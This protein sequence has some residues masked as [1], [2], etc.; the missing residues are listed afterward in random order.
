MNLE[1][2]NTLQTEHRCLLGQAAQIG[3]QL[4]MIRRGCD[5]DYSLL[6][7]RVEFLKGHY[8]EVHCPK[9]KV[10]IEKLV[11]DSGNLGAVMAPFLNAH[12]SAFLANMREFA[13]GLKAVLTERMISRDHLLRYGD[14]ALYHL[15]E[16]VATEEAGPLPWA[17]Q[18]LRRRDWKDVAAANGS[19]QQSQVADCASIGYL[20]PHLD[21]Q[22]ASAARSRKPSRT[23]LSATAHRHRDY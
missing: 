7:E 19:A 14:A 1:T 5:P 23:A 6:H 13:A 15:R 9:D 21:R 22:A 11:G 3:E 18:R 17:R 4:E 16:Q 12:E 2:L 8:I 20:F 10:M